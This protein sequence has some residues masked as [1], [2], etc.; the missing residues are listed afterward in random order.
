MRVRNKHRH[1]RAADL[2]AIG[3]K[4][5]ANADPLAVIRFVA[6]DR[7]GQVHIADGYTLDD[8]ATE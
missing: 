1:R 3:E 2:R 7:D 5:R 6:H 4:R 8:D